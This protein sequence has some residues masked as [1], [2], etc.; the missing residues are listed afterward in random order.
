MELAPGQGLE[1]EESDFAPGL[2]NESDEIFLPM[3]YLESGLCANWTNG[4]S[5]PVRSRGS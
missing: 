3:P 2:L 1:V 4:G 5:N